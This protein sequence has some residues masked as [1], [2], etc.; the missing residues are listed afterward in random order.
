MRNSTPACSQLRICGGPPAPGTSGSFERTAGMSTSHEHGTPRTLGVSDGTHASW[1]GAAVRQVEKATLFQ[2]LSGPFQTSQ[3]S[4]SKPPLRPGCGVPTVISYTLLGISTLTNHVKNSDCRQRQTSRGST[5][6]PRPQ[7]SVSRT[8]RKTHYQVPRALPKRVG[9]W[10]PMARSSARTP[11]SE[12]PLRQVPYHRP[13]QACVV[14]RTP[15]CSHAEP[16]F[17]REGQ[18]VPHLRLRPRGAGRP[19]KANTTPPIPAPIRRRSAVSTTSRFQNNTTSTPP[20]NH[21][22]NENLSAF[23]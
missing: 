20:K 14:D 3:Q 15:W 4:R 16:L 5:R 8:G 18:A 12:V 10:A 1:L 22:R 17:D 21:W 6:I 9:S 11:R 23:R 19:R 2:V 13:Q 7:H